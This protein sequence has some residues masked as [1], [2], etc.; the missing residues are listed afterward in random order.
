MAPPREYD[1][2]VIRKDGTERIVELHSTS[3]ITASGGAKVIIQVLDITE[4]RQNQRELKLYSENLKELVEER[5]QKLIQS[6]TMALL[7]TMVSGTAP[8]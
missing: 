3:Y 7:G 4:Q 8:S 5:T 1:I 6:E 2:V